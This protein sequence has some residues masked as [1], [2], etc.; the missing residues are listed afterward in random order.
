MDDPTVEDRLIQAERYIDQL[1]RVIARF[2]VGREVRNLYHDRDSPV[3]PG[4]NWDRGRVVRAD[5]DMLVVRV[6][7][8][9]D[10]NESFLATVHVSLVE[11][12]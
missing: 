4:N 9:S 10:Y 8:L 5:G 7:E 2:A 3:G 12:L 11:A 6:P 1:F